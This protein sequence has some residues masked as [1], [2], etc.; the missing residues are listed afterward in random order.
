MK[1]FPL[2]LTNRVPGVWENYAAHFDTI[3]DDAGLWYRTGPGLQGLSGEVDASGAQSIS[4][5]C[6]AACGLPVG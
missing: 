6:S 3:M 5:G 2:R 4:A 1:T